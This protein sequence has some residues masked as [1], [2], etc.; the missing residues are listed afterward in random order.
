MRIEKV[1]RSPS[2]A[3]SRLKA[4]LAAY[5]RYAA[6][7][8]EQLR[9]LQEEDI[10]RFVGL[11]DDRA[12]IQEEL[13]AAPEEASEETLDSEAPGLLEEARREL[14][15]VVG[16]D[17]EIE[18]RLLRLRAEIGGRIRSLSSQKGNARRYVTEGE[19]PPENR[20]PRLNVRL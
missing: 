19:S 16:I 8:Q 5:S 1:G 20:P 12:E 9:A 6:V 14:G 11:A 10:D 4:R 7:V 3:P 2:A 13:E 15:V 18:A 17:R